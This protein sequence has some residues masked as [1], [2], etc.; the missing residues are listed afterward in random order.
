MT[1]FLKRRT[2]ETIKPFAVFI[3]DNF[4]YMATSARSK[5][6]EYE[7]YEAAVAAC[8]AIVDASLAEQY[9]RGMRADELYQRY[10]MFGD[11]PWVTP[12][13]EGERFS[14]WDYAKQQCTKRAGPRTKPGKPVSD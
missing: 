9:A 2:A 12:A 1:D 8:K 7:T 11:D 14:A 6:R 5:H 10:V 3:D 13:P 4:D